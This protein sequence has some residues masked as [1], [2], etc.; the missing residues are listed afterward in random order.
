MPQAL[1]AGVV[2]PSGRVPLERGVTRGQAQVLA[3][4]LAPQTHPLGWQSSSGRAR[5]NATDLPWGE[6]VALGLR[7]TT[8]H[9]QKC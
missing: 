2:L 3:Q 7:G 5:S 4:Y 1:A 6:T 8:L 9:V